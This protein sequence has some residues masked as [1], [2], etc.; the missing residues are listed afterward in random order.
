MI[1]VTGAVLVGLVFGSFATVL[2]ERVPKGEQ[3]QTGRSRCE[4]CS[5]PIAWYDNVPVLSWLLLRGKCRSCATPISP[6][7]PLIEIGMG[8]GFGL[9]FLTVDDLVLATVL[10]YML[11][12]GTVLSVI[13]VLH[14][15]LPDALV[16]PSYPIIGAGLILDFLVA[17]GSGSLWRAAAGAG[18]ALGIYGGLWLVYPK[19]IGFGDV[20][21]APL[22]GMVAGYLGWAQLAVG[23]FAAPF[24]GLIAAVIVGMRRGSIA[25]TRIPYGPAIL[26]GMWV[27]LMSG[28]ALADVY[29]GVVGAGS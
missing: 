13:D 24:L 19:G 15:R 11:W 27:G 28:P 4:E 16:A 5:A 21:L 17:H 29:L 1:V 22:I 14:M 6:R 7:Y 3:W 18:I 20:K 10:A 9:V 23:L 2:I 26:V 25:K 8:A 12:L